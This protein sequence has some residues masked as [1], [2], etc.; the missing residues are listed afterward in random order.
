M[1]TFEKLHALLASGQEA[2]TSP[3]S[4]ASLDLT[5]TRYENILIWVHLHG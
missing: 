4:E 1:M 3:E 2:G 5:M